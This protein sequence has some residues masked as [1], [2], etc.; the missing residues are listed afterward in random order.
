MH[1]SNVHTGDPMV[2]RVVPFARPV[3]DRPADRTSSS[4][5]RPLRNHP[6]ELL[7]KTLL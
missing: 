4:P 6:E 5:T 7:I 3:T 1:A 2:L